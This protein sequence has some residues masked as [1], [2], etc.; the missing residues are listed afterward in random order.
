MVDQFLNNINP[1]IPATPINMKI[2]PCD[3]RGKD[4]DKFKRY[5]LYFHRVS[6]VIL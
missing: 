6:K 3:Y 5:M 1:A 4:I 2:N